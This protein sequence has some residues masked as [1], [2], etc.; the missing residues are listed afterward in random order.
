MNLFSNLRLIGLS[1]LVTFASSGCVLSLG[2]DPGD[3]NGQ[4]DGGT[5]T[6]PNNP[7]AAGQSCGLNAVLSS[8][9]DCVCQAGH[10]WCDPR[11]DPGSGGRNNCCVG[12]APSGSQACESGSN[13]ILLDKGT[14]DPKD[15]QCVCIQGFDWCNAVDTTDLNCC[16]NSSTQPGTGGT[17]PGKVPEPNQSCDPATDT[18]WCSHTEAQGP[19]GSRSFSCVNGVW[20]DATPSLDEQ[21]KLDAYDFAYGCVYVAPKGNDKAYNKLMCGVGPGTDCDNNDADSCSDD[22]SQLLYCEYGKLSAE[23]CAPKEGEA[24]KTKDNKEFEFGKCG[25]QN[26][27]L[28]C[29]CYDED[30]GESTTTGGET[31]GAGSGTGDT[32]TGA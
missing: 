10:S 7:K 32:G 23:Q 28:S 14:V 20:V 2:N 17:D 31:E 26:G 1:A 25:S 24:C 21:C 15:D 4:G 27:R 18:S 12:Q 8:N 9:L 30:P 19:Q 29:L 22:E 11:L 3:G 5:S 6:L 13:N 16:Y